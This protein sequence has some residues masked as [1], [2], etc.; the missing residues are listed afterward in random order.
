MGGF[1]SASHKNNKKNMKIIESDVSILKQEPGIEGL[2]KHMETVGRISHMSESKGSPKDFIERIKKLGHWAVF[3]LGTVYLRFPYEFCSIDGCDRIFDILGNKWTVDVRDQGY[4]HITT[5]FRSILKLGCLD[6]MEKLWCDPI[7]GVHEKRLTSSWVCS[8]AIGNEL[9]RHRAFSFIQESTR[10]IN[11]SR[12]KFGTELTYIVPEWVEKFRVPG[13]DDSLSKVE[14]WEK[15]VSSVPVISRR[16]KTWKE[17]EEEYLWETQE[18]ILVP[19]D[20]RGCLPGDLKTTI[21]MCGFLKDYYDTPEPGS[22]EKLGFFYLREAPDAHPD[23][24]VLAE[25]LNREI[26]ENKE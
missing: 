4:H 25:K 15:Y 6:L 22:E 9:V 8:R 21:Y 13:E 20:A 18:K 23:I 12:E 3:D 2:Y 14:L 19:G 5:T 24:R 16:N 11:Y 10:F 1:V 7:P 17:A 26:H